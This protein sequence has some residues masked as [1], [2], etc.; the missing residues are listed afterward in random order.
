M[1]FTFS[2][3][4]RATPEQALDAFIDFG[5][6]R[7]HIWRET[8]DPGRY[9][10]RE[11]HDGW[12]VVKEGTAKPPIWAVERYDWSR[13]GAVR[14]RALESDFCRPG[15]GVEVTIT[16]RDDGGSHVDGVWHRSPRGLKG[17]LIVP[18]IR[19]VGPRSFPG[20][21]RKVLDRFADEEKPEG[22]AGTG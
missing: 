15:S 18:L 14:W 5:P 4:T 22:A 2:F 13:P 12:A 10:V 16:A 8:L 11:L 6:R 21:W 7:P 20:D 19:L 3:D 9:E 17:Y 1:R